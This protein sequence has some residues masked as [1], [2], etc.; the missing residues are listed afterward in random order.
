VI[1]PRESRVLVGG[2]LF[3]AVTVVA[4]VLPA[5]RGWRADKIASASETTLR[6]QRVASLLALRAVIKDS[7]KSRKLRLVEYDSVYLA[8]ASTASN[9]AMLAAAIADDAEA[10]DTKLA[11]VQLQTDSS[12]AAPFAR[13]RARVTAVGDLQS[14]ALFLSTLEVGPPLLS[15][16]EL[17]L[18]QP[19]AAIPP[20]RIETIRADFV[21]DALMLKNGEPR[22]AIARRSQ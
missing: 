9:E 22:E 11:S 20:N 12:R 8:G 1:T 5:I 3:V 18:A 17:S 21:I 4:R 19:D 2:L 16:R 6:W 14:I 10:T 13:I 15:V 7:L